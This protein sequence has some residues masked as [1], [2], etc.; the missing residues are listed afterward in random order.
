M[1]SQLIKN[2]PLY[3]NFHVITNDEGISHH[4]INNLVWE[5]N[6]L[7]IIVKHIKDNSIFL[8]IGANLGCHSVGVANKLKNKY[9]LHVVA[10]EPQ[11]F[12]FELLQK[13]MDICG[14]SHECHQIGLGPVEMTIY[15]DLPNYK[16]CKNPGGFG[17]NLNDNDDSKT[18]I[19]IKTLDSFQ[20]NNVSVIKLDV[21]GLEN[22]VLKGGYDT[23]QRCKPIMIIEI[24]G[25]VNFDTAKSDQKKYINETIDHIK[26]LGYNVSKVS[27][28]DYLCIP[29]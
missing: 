19:S 17:L 23:I 21:E 18:M 11:P 12:I 9:K 29:I 14:I 28:H 5:Q 20:Y 2:H 7:D 3:G 4:L 8:D 26:S 1:T 10:F 15:S 6:I 27:V 16:N 24:L 13:N 25:G 22:E